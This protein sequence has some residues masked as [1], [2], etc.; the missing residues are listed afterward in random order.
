LISQSTQSIVS[1]RDQRIDSRRRARRQITVEQ[2]R[3]RERQEVWRDLFNRAAL[4][5]KRRN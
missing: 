2:R 5:P 3:A 1:K 4:R